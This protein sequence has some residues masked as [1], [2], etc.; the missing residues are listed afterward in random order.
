MGHIKRFVI[1][2]VPNFLKIGFAFLITK[3]NEGV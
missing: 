1:S 2:V 3:S